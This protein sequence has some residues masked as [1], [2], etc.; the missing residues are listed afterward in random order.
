MMYSKTN[1]TTKHYL[2][3]KLVCFFKMLPNKI[4]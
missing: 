4:K 3:L 2:S 1:M